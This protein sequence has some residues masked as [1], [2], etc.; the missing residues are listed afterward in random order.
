M[1]DM[2]VLY[3]HA[4]YPAALVNFNN[5]NKWAKFQEVHLSVTNH[6]CPICECSLKVGELLSR[7]SRGKTKQCIIEST[8]DHYRP[9]K[10]YTFLALTHENYILM[11]SE[12]NNIYKGC[13][14][15]LFG[16]NPVR[17]TNPA[18]ISNEQ[19]LIVNPI[20]DD[21]F[22]LFELV[23]RHDLSGRKVLE[24]SPKHEQGYRYEKALTTIKLFSLGEC[25]LNAHSNANVKTLRINLLHSHF[26]KFDV[27][28]DAF[29][30]KNIPK[31]RAEI[32]DKNLKD[33]GFLKFILKNQF[34]NLV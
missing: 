31:M 18:E 17:A 3:D 14:F 26:V 32:A 5:S 15:P 7:P 6:K 29:M 16:D 9:Q 28:I 8:V 12:C 10:Y 22:D 11:C 4:D 20:N 21:L 19:P 27:F 34:K 2:S 24:L 13:E 25:E 33:Y 30:N 1:I 23:V